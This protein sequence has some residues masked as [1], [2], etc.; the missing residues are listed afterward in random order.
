MISKRTHGLPHGKSCSIH[1]NSQYFGRIWLVPLHKK[2]ISLSAHLKF[3]AL[4]ALS[5][6][7]KYLPKVHRPRTAR[8]KGFPLR[9]PVAN[10]RP[11]C[12]NAGAQGH[13][14][15][16]F[17]LLTY[18]ITSCYIM[19]S[20]TVASRMIPSSIRQGVQDSKAGV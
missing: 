15:D 10:V 12:S 20:L 17:L 7:I 6:L 1:L 18:Q 5:P 3:I 2:I 11:A 19:L 16:V 4:S 9:R 14:F 13:V 8:R